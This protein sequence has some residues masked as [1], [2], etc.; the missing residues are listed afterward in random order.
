M[1]ANEYNH[2]DCSAED[3]RKDESWSD[4]RGEHGVSHGPS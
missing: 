4:Y 3:A 2:R 1:F